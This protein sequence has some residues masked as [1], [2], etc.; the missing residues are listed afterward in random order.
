MES[1]GNLR[2]WFGGGVRDR[3]QSDTRTAWAETERLWQQSALA[4][5]PVSDHALAIVRAAIQSAPRVPSVPILVALCEATEAIL[6]LEDIGA[7]DAD[8]PIIETNATVAVAVR[9]MLTRRRRFISD[10][11]RSMSIVAGQLISA[12]HLLFDALPESCFIEGDEGAET[13]EV[14]LLSIIPW[15]RGRRSWTWK[16]NSASS[17][18]RP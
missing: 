3:E 1:W 14:P 16:R 13:F 4:D 10:L 12:F 6:R 15:R 2:N 9:Q 8:W 17:R 18:T 11:D 5:T 7:L